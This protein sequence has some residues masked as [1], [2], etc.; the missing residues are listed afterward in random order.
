M[1]GEYESIISC[2]NRRT[3]YWAVLIEVDP[4]EHS[5][6]KYGE[7]VR[8]ICEMFKESTKD[9]DH[10][11]I[12]RLNPSGQFSDD[13]MYTQ[14]L[15]LYQRILTLRCWMYW[16]LRLITS[17]NNTSVP[18]RLLLYMFYT[19]TDA[20]NA[21][22]QGSWAKIMQSYP[23]DLKDCVGWTMSCPTDIDSAT[24]DT[25]PA[26]K[27]HVDPFEVIPHQ[28]CYNQNKR[29]T[30]EVKSRS[31]YMRYAPKVTPAIVWPVLF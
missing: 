26:W 29:K 7:D 8:R 18:K 30:V 10:V 1:V 14:N 6:A 22:N 31:G 28:K 21:Q 27:Y 17:N 16:Y 12:I 9:Y 20:R 25:T 4:N 15:H 5:N 19:H 2:D 24:D 3:Y 11:F 23:D 13:S